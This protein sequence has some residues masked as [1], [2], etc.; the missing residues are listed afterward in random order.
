L[1]KQVL[2]AKPENTGTPRLFVAATRQN[3]GKT[4]TCLWLFAALP[5]KFKEVG[6]IK[7]IGHR[8][9]NY[10]NHLVD[11]DSLLFNKTY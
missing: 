3:D 5:H 7:P 1:S 9:I 11:E 8:F 10:H 2:L 6:Y 4:T